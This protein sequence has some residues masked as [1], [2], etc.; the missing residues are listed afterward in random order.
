MIQKRLVDKLALKLLEG[1]F[2]PGDRVRVDAR[3]GELEL[4]AA[5]L[6]P[7]SPWRPAP[8]GG[9][10]STQAQPGRRGAPGR[11][12]LDHRSPGR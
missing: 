11:D 6:P 10:P 1:E 4:T 12:R 8:S 2:V 7:P 9:P 5:G 3:D